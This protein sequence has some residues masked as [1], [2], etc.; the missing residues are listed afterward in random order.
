MFAF[1]NAIKSFNT[2][3]RFLP[4]GMLLLLADVCKS[5]A[6]G[7][8]GTGWT[9]GGGAGLSGRVGR[10]A[11][12]DVVGAAFSVPCG[13]GLILI[14][15]NLI[16]VIGQLKR[17]AHYIQI[18]NMSNNKLSLKSQST[19]HWVQCVLNYQN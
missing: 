8:L 15:N 16:I 14:P 1:K 10:S 2:I 17:D 7:E 13:V 11:M 4:L 19:Y 6:W 12:L 3:N 5:P 18:K 9:G